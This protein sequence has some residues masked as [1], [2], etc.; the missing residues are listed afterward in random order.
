[1]KFT[2]RKRSIPVIL[3]A[4]LALAIAALYLPSRNFDFIVLDDSE[5]VYGNELVKGG[6]SLE[7]VRKAFTESHQDY[8]VPLNWLSLMADSEFYGIDAGGFHLTNTILQVINGLLLFAFLYRATGSPWKSF[9]AAA[10]WALHP[11]RVESVAWITERKDLLSGLFFLL[12]LLSWLKYSKEKSKGWYLAS[13]AAMLAGLASKPVLVIMPLILLAADYWPL[14]RLRE[15][16]RGS[17]LKKLLPEKIP[18]FALSALFSFLTLYFQKRNIALPETTPLSQRLSEVPVSYAHYLWKTI[19]PVNLVIENRADT[20]PSVILILTGTALLLALT[21][22]AFKGRIF[23]PAL[24][25]GWFWFV[26]ALFPVSGIVSVGLNTMADRFTYLPHMGLFFGL[27]WGIGSLPSLKGVPGKS[28][29]FSGALILGILFAFSSLQLSRWKDGVTLFAYHFDTTGSA[30]AAN[31]LANAYGAAG[32]D[33]LSIRYFEESIKKNPF[34][35]S[36]WNNLGVKYEKTGRYPEAIE[37]FKKSLE[38]RPDTV[39]THNCNPSVWNNLG[40]TYEKA[41]KY[42]EAIEAFSRAL[43]PGPGAGAAYC[44]G[45]AVSG[46]VAAIV[47]PERELS[48]RPE[49]FR[50][51]YNL[52]KLYKREGQDD[53]A[54]EAFQKA[55]EQNPENPDAPG[56]LGLLFAK[57]GRMDEAQKYFALALERDPEN[58]SSN[59]FMA[60]ALLEAGQTSRA[61]G[62]F[63]KALELSPGNPS[64]H[65]NYGVLLEKEG[66][67]A[68]ADEQYLEVQKLDPGGEFSAPARGRMS[69]NP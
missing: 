25:S 49:Y 24:A 64:A 27:V 23:S 28:A 50:A 68:E 44:P 18:F 32:N 12:C 59:L 69:A 40:V 3:A 52:G 1:M 43:K 31:A 65:Y 13:L 51:W 47:S 62:F 60:L 8:W 48:L 56:E 14:G 11:L 66:R 21:F 41:G 17:G 46:N 39:D 26:A 33:E 37:A 9:F 58:F 67:R 34:S 54:I 20:A 35:P 22:L 16:E 57:A 15:N 10:L 36:V 42:P 19:W 61:E 30:F 4:V 29:A 2:T 55:H 53:K 6:F 45:V 7:G 5:Y 63:K 38:L